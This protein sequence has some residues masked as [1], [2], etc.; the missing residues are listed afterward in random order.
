MKK[1]KI[2]FW[3]TTTLIFLFEGVMPALTSQS[4]IAV[5]GITHLGYPV[6][7]GTMLMVFKVAGSIVLII[8]KFSK[9]VKE[10]AY[11]GFGIDFLS[12]FISLLVIDGLSGITFF[13]LVVFG[14]L[15]VSYVSYHK[16]N[17]SW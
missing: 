13:P 2:M 8:P 7:F 16:L 4:D 11:A 1:Y 15:A 3:I 6:Y 10:W 5:Q 12:A 14:V 17:S 9:R